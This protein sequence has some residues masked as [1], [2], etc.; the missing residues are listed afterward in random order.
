ME[1]IGMITSQS[2]LQQ[3]EY[4]DRDGRRQ[5]FSSVGFELKSGTNRFYAELTGEQAVNAR[6]ASELLL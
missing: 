4:T 6:T 3:R 5:V 1:E 2:P